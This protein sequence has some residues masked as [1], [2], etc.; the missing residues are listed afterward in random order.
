MLSK[1]AIAPASAL[2]LARF[3]V[4]MAAEV[5]MRIA[6]PGGVGQVGP[7]I[8]IESARRV[9]AILRAV[10]I[11][12]SPHLVFL[13]RFKRHRVELFQIGRAHV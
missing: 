13:E 8:G 12:I 2:G 10:Q 3:P 7:A 4:R 6:R 1:A 11:Q 9:E 5:S